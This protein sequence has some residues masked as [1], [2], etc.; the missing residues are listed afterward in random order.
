[1]SMN[2]VVIMPPDA[3]RVPG[4]MRLVI[5]SDTHNVDV[6]ESL[7]PPG[8]L[9]IH[10]GDHTTM[11]L[12]S[13]LAG[14]AAWL[15]SLAARFTHGVVAI[16]GNHDRPLDTETWL[17]AAPHSQPEEPWTTESMAK[18]RSLFDN[19]GERSGARG[20]M[21]LLQHAATEIAALK[22]FGS[23]YVGFTPR[24]QAMAPD[25]PLRQ[26]G[27]LRDHLR[28]AELYADI[29][30]GLDVLIT[31]SPPLGVLDS[32]VQ[33]GGVPREAPIAIGSAA[34][35]DRLY[36]MVRADRPRLHVFGHEHDAR[37]VFCDQ[38]LGTV[39]V[40]AAAVN[41]DQGVIRSGG[42]YVMKEGFRPFVVDIRVNDRK[43]ALQVAKNTDG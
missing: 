8:D 38:E 42:G 1:M 31:H 13:E 11:G 10:A 20:P 23:P 3:P 7:F 27:F 39:F 5:V 21:R 37:G 25:N 30:T 14:A 15:R 16:A 26:E 17:H 34:L 19:G 36:G 24:R 4:W 32:S 12:A 35:R 6:P 41:G 33:Y 43:G 22:L 40:N 9:L 28:L 2:D 18:V 29:P